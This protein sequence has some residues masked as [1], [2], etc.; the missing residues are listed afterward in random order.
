MADMKSCGDADIVYFDIRRKWFVKY[1]I[2]GLQPFS[3]KVE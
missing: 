2:C 1:C 3:L